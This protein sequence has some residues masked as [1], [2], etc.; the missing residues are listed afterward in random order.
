MVVGKLVFTSSLFG[1]CYV[2]IKKMTFG[3]YLFFT[4]IYN[5]MSVQINNVEMYDVAYLKDK[6][7]TYFSGFS[8]NVFRIVKKKE[9]PESEYVYASYSTKTGWKVLEKDTTYARKKMLITKKWCDKNIPGLD[10][11]QTDAEYD[12]LP[13]LLKLDDSEKFTDEKNNVVNIQIR[14]EK[15]HVDNVFFR[16]VDIGHMLEID[17]IRT[18][19]TNGT[20]TFQK[21][22]HYTYFSKEKSD[23]SGGHTVAMYLTYGGLVK[24]L[25][26]SKKNMA[27]HFQRWAVTTLFTVQM[28]SHDDKQQLG[29]DV[30]G[31]NIKAIKSFLNTSVTATPVVYMFT[32]GKVKDLR[33]I[34]NIPESF[35]DDDTVVKYGLSKDLR[36]RSQEHEKTFGKLLKDVPCAEM[37]LKYHVYIDQFYLSDAETDVGKYFKGAHWSLDN[38]RFEE[39]A[40]IPDHMLNSIVH[41]EF[42]RIGAEYGGKLQDLQSQLSNSNKLN[43]RLE[44]TLEMQKASHDQFVDAQKAS[45]DALKETNERIIAEK[46]NV[47]DEKEKLIELY[48]QILERNLM[49]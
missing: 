24:L 15:R 5:E 21:G 33:A 14:G 39:L 49:S 7:P 31:V 48:R 26:S 3:S 32:L 35:N 37:V 13:P 9:V 19:I 40:C 29:S 43:E 42:K 36:R 17:Q 12:P 23:N 22:V 6:I 44:M 16:T 45:N 47:V 38:D 4:K 8:T 41:N 2:K 25:F 10:T 30:L 20:S 34:L 28:G 46:Q 18:T 27:I 11:S 1:T